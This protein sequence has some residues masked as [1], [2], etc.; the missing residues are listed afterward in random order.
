MRR[1][2]IM[3]V[4]LIITLCIAGFKPGQGIDGKWEGTVQGDQDNYSLV[5][6]F[7]RQGNLLKGTVVSP[8]GDTIA[9]DNG[10]INGDSFTF[11]VSY[12]YETYHHNGTL[13]GDTV[14][15]KIEGSGGDSFTGKFTRAS[16]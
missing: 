8:S 1:S 10:K 15:M 9:I 13:K 2:A 5:Y 11:D 7:N 14:T 3:Y 4:S 12:N 6:T 16:D